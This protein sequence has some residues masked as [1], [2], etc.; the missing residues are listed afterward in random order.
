MPDN[1]ESETCSVE[2]RELNCIEVYICLD[3]VWSVKD[4]T[5]LSAPDRVSWISGTFWK[6][7]PVYHKRPQT[8]HP[9]FFPVYRL[10]VILQLEAIYPIVRS[11]RRESRRKQMHVISPS[12]LEWNH[13]AITWCVCTVVGVSEV[14][15][16]VN[17]RPN[18][19]STLKYL[20][21]LSTPCCQLLRS[22]TCFVYAVSSPRM[23]YK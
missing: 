20:R 1:L 14:W 2:I 23:D 13:E 15:M 6:S 7:R 3:C 5:K 8:F 19:V 4:K 10:T 22:G 17:V 12:L 18:A 16:Q 11:R 9:I 21:A